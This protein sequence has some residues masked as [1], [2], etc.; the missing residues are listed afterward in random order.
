[1]PHLLISCF[2]TALHMT[3]ASP[4][5]LIREGVVSLLQ[6]HEELVVTRGFVRVVDQGELLVLRLDLLLIGRGG[7]LKRRVSSLLCPSRT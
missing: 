3:E 4:R 5:S 2:F 7:H 6:L 1:M